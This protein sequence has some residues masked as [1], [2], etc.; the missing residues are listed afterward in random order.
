MTGP[1]EGMWTC[2]VCGA[3]RPD[4]LISVHKTD[5]SADFGLPPGTWIENV[6]Y[7]NDRPECV[8]G[9]PTVR[10]SKKPEVRP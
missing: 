2:H 10:F 7:C 6:R 4:A 3:E 9:A 5:R 8:A 1:G